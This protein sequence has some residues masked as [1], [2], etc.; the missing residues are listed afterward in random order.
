M[1]KNRDLIKV[2]DEIIANIPEDE[3][4]RLRVDLTKIKRDL[5]FT[6]PECENIRWN[7][8]YRHLVDSI[9]RQLIKEWQFK[10]WAIFKGCTIKEIKELIK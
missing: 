5:I 2:I 8:V 1:T 10:V 4:S 3:K 6:A 9:G 7:D